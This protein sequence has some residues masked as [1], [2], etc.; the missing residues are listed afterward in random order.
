VTEFE[1]ISLAAIRT[2]EI[3]DTSDLEAG[4]YHEIKHSG[5]MALV[6]VY[7]ADGMLIPFPG[8]GPALKQIPGLV[9]IPKLNAD[10]YPLKVVLVGNPNYP[11][12][13]DGLG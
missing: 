2:L 13:R 9:T 1:L 12:T 8:P 5:G 6:Q 4:H 10:Y 3:L 11:Y 7:T